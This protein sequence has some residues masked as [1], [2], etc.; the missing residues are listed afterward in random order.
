MEI[1][2]IDFK[3][4]RIPLIYEFNQSLPIVQFKMIFKCAGIVSERKKGIAK[5]LANLL[6]EGTKKLGNVEF[7]R[8]LEIRAIDLDFGANFETFGA[9][10]DCLSEHFSF[11][12]KALC[13][14]F[15][16]PNF[17]EET[18]QKLKTKTLGEIAA[19]QSDFDAQAR[20]ELDKLLYPKTNLA[21]DALGDE[22]SVAGISLDDLREF[23]NENFGINNVFFTLCGDVELKNVDFSALLSKFKGVNSQKLPFLRTS[24]GQK[25]KFVKRD[26]KQAYVYFGA[27]FDVK[28]EQKYLANVATFILGSS[29]FGSRLMEEIRVKRGLAYGAYAKNALK[30]SHSAIL[31]YLQTKNESKNEAIELVKSEFVKF[32][33]SGVT[34]EELDAAKNFLLGSEPL[35]KET[36]FKRVDIAQSEFYEGYEQGEFERRLAKIKALKLS[37]LNEFIKNHAEIT[38]LSFAVIYNEI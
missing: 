18:L 12:F 4:A 26:T 34:S 10:I 32:V 30:L 2:N 6:N 27:P 29:G 17:S 15:A 25:S 11:A 24:D 5:M 37:E 8:A 31:G 38:K 28:K 33:N 7:N 36:L 9:Q 35:S 3:T 21:Y 22:K 14:I 20:L 1:V 16:D 23:A 13:D 19:K